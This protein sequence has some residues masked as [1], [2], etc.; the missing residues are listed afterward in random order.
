LTQISE[1]LS[2]DTLFRDVPIDHPV[3]VAVSG[4]SDSI[5]LLLLADIWAHKNDVQ[6]QAVTI[7]HGLRPEAAAEAAFVAGVCAGLGISHVTLA[8]EGIKPSFGIQEAARQS[9]YSL[10]DDYAHEIGA[11]VILTGHTRDDQVE[12]V[13]MRSL[14]GADEPSQ[15]DGRGLA[16]MAGKTWLY[17]GRRIIRPLLGQDRETLRAYLAG[18][19]QAWIEDPSNHD[20][21]FERVRLRQ[22]LADH[23]LEKARTEAL[24]ALAARFRSV[25]AQAVADYLARACVVSPGPVYR[26]TEAQ[27]PEKS[28]PVFAQAV[29]ALI[30][31]AGGQL[32]FISRRRLSGALE[33]ISEMKAGTGTPD[34][35]SRLTLGGAVIEATRA[36]VFFY[37]EVRNLTSVLLEPGEAAIWDGRMHIYNGA[38]FPVFI[39][40]AGR[41]QIREYETARG[42]AYDV[43]RRAALWSTPVVHV[44]SDSGGSTPCLP[45]VES[46]RPAK[47][48][49]IRLASPAI[50]H[51]C[52]QHDA[53]LRNWVLLLDRHGAA[54]LQ[55]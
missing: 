30:A 43:T 38:T 42:E 55:P 31:I 1:P 41:S 22:Y 3:L 16:G 10:M 18:V 47:G 24:A 35:K 9:R 44:Q 49:E 6:L 46:A 33:M 25:Q 45:L 53:A 36:G 14:R 8:W 34:K 21:S 5:A 20:R 52:P 17:G 48:L 54:S 13:L 19:P 28:N 4:G 39:E 12:T 15:G 23:P 37:R 32:H 26:L 40:P 51:F 29:Q 2:P 50:E 7:D 11:D 27:V